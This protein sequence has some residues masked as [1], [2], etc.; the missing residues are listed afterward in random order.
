MD[1]AG[2]AKT[3]TIDYAGKIACVVFTAGCNY[4]CW[5]C[6]NKELLSNPL[7]LDEHEFFSFLKKRAS[8]LEGVVISGGEPTQQ[9][10]L[11]SFAL[12]IKEMGYSI[13][14]D[15]NGS[16]P[17]VLSNLLQ[18]SAVDYVAV[19]YK[20][21]FNRYLSVCKH[22]AAGVQECAGI[23][24]KSHISWE[25]RTTVIPQLNAGD[26]IAMS[27]EFL[28]L[29][30]YALQRYRPIDDDESSAIYSPSQICEFA[31]MLKGY[32]PNV[33]ARI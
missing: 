8:M 14:L 18:N 2:L 11:L 10:D 32:Q 3:S 24:Q 30:L 33:I 20:A 26:L 7:L 4:K 15:T 9:K 5:Y 19:D 16:N 13:K 25:M 27:R 28:K 17:K 22:D 1:I 29:P 21:P 23:L 31:R 12:K 6:H